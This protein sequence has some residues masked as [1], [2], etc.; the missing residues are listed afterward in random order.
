MSSV[1]RS[2]SIVALGLHRGSIPEIPRLRRLREAL[3][4]A[5]YG[6]CTQKAELL[7]E[8][9]RAHWPVP[10]LTK[11]LAPLHFKALRKTL[12]E[13]LATGKPAKHWQLVSSKYL[14]ELWLH[15]DEHT[16][17]EA[18]IVAFAHGLAHVLDNMELRIYDDELLVG[19]PTRHRVGAALHPDY[20]ALLLL[21]E[22]HQIATR[23]V[24]P[25]KISDAQIEALDH[26]IFPFWFTRSI[27]SRAPLF[28][29]D[30]ELQNKLT[31][32]RRFVLTQFAGISH[33]TL[34]FP[35]VLEIGFE[36]LRA[37]IVE[38]KQAEE[39]GAA[40]PRRLAFY[41]AAEL[42]VDAVLRFAQRWSEHCEREADRLAATDPAR[43]EE[44]RALARILTQVPARPARTF[45]EALQSVITTWVVIHQES[46]Q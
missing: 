39:S 22:L 35:A 26:D 6:L 40:D 18:P 31:E 45:H 36:G 9:M 4:D 3:L 30:I 13:N 23:P 32:G 44:L 7:T 10:A 19:N 28:S 38:A 42:S 15:L 29:D 17:I 27:M 33:V 41:Q 21:P 11:R 46:F 8:S 12:E 34:D 2:S 25:L 37:R 43:A 20:G 5:E 1:A 24:N 16:E 14:Q